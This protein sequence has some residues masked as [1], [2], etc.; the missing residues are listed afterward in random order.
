MV[1]KDHGEVNKK[2]RINCRSVTGHKRRS[3][4]G[5]S[6]ILKANPPPGP[7][8]PD[9]LLCHIK[10]TQLPVIKLK[11]G[12]E[13]WVCRIIQYG[14]Y[15]LRLPFCKLRSTHNRKIVWDNTVWVSRMR[16]FAISW[17]YLINLRPTE[18]WF[19][20]HYISVILKLSLIVLNLDVQCWKTRCGKVSQLHLL[21]QCVKLI[22]N[23]HFILFIT[24]SGCG[25]RQWSFVRVVIYGIHNNLD[26]VSRKLFSGI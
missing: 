9:F 16:I 12:L 1:E 13:L 3:P 2:V 15:S 8:H 4:A 14:C 5:K 7:P 21:F 22:F 19:F 24:F 17:I 20:T 11:V 25:Y 26:L 6:H 10:G 23:H 18:R